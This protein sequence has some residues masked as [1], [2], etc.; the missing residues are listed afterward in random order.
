MS[1]QA[2]QR[3]TPAPLYTAKREPATD[4]KA[5]RSRPA[6]RPP[7]TTPPGKTAA[8]AKDDHKNRSRKARRRARQTAPQKQPARRA[9]RILALQGAAR[10]PNDGNAT[11]KKPTVAAKAMAFRQTANPN[12]TRNRR[13]LTFK[14]RGWPTAKLGR[15][16]ESSITAGRKENAYGQSLSN[17]GLGR[18]MGTQAEQRPTPAPLYTA[19]REAATDK[20]ARRGR[21]AWL[22][23]PTTPPGKTA[24]VTKGDHINRS[25][26]TKRRARQTAQQNNLPGDPRG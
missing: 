20:I 6:W 13:G 26:E 2:E 11:A 15:S 7:P 23:P 24:A 10:T 9:A 3:P 16:P 5:R 1:A 12:S 17:V 19:K 8:V 4:K 22:S 14:L 21:P 18:R 25:R